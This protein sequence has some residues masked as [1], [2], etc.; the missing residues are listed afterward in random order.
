MLFK[1]SNLNSN[2]AL[3]LGYLN[4]VNLPLLAGGVILLYVRP[5]FQP[6]PPQNYCTVSNFRF[7]FHAF[8]VS[9]LGTSFLFFFLLVSKVPRFSYLSMSEK[10]PSCSVVILESTR[11][12]LI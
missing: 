1:L 2:L 11:A 5:I 6:P 4:R 3:T 7:D 10:V 9:L 8:F 12:G